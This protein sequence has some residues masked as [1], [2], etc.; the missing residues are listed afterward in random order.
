M[1]GPE[2]NYRSWMQK[3]ESDL[4]NIENN[5]AATRVPWDTVCFHAQQSVEKVLKGFLVFHS[6]TPP[7]IHDL[8]AL[9]AACAQID[10][11]LVT[12]EADCAKLTDFAI[13]AR[14]PTGVVEPGAEDSHAA[15]AAALRV[16]ATLLA[17]LPES[18]EQATGDQSTN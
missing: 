15:V 13:L 5:L 7:R 14:Y 17:N 8:V 12:L 10:P 16:R 3:A 4:L 18:D 9:L 11:S 6:Q 1:S 2:A